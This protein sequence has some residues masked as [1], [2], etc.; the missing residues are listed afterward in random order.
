MFEFGAV[1]H[2]RRSLG[3]RYGLRII[4]GTNSFLV[5]P[6]N[7]SRS[8]AVGAIL[9]PGGPTHAPATAR[10]G[11]MSPDAT[12]VNSVGGDLDFML[13]VSGDEKLLRRLNEFESAETCSTSGKGTDARWKLEP[14]EA[15]GA[16]WHFANVL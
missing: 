9:H 11:W 5:L 16:L 2:M 1:A 15:A 7:I 8:T 3:E 13:S 12:D 4:P 6:N 10:A 14:R